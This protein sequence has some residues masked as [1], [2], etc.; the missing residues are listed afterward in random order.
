MVRVYP[1]QQ[2]LQQQQ[3]GQRQ[4]Q[5]PRTRPAP[6]PNHPRVYEPLSLGPDIGTVPN[7]V[8]MVSMHTGLEGNSIPGPLIPLLGSYA[9]DD[10][11]HHNH[12]DMG[13]LASYFPERAR[14]GAGLMVM[15]GISPNQEGRFSPLIANLTTEGEAESQRVVTEAVQ[16]IKVPT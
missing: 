3:K 6:D 2:K 8:I 16:S 11:D 1:H 5:Q 12:T 9:D 10:D 4:Q 15:G 14:G 7:R 13:R